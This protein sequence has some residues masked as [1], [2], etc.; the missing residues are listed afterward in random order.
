[1]TNEAEKPLKIGMVCPY[2]WAFPGG[3][4]NHTI[5]LTESLR[6]KGHDVTIIAPHSRPSD[7]IFSAGRAYPV[8]LIRGGTVARVGVSRRGYKRV[9]KF[10]RD[11]NFDIIHVQEPVAPLSLYTLSY[12]VNP[13]VNAVVTTSHTNTPHNWQTRLEALVIKEKTVRNIAANIDV[14]IAVS[15]TAKSFVERY[16]PPGQYVIIPNGVDT[17]RFS[18]DVE[19]LKG[20][21]GKT[22]LFVG[23]LGNQETRKGL[24]FLVQAFNEFSWK[25]PDTE[26]VIAG[27][28][29]PDSSTQAMLNAIDHSKIK[30]IGGVSNE[31]L[32]GLY[33]AADIFCTPATRGE[34]FG[35][36]I[37][38]AMASG[39]PVIASHIPG[40]SDVMST[41][42]EGSQDPIKYPEYSLAQVG[43]GFMVPPKDPIALARGLEIL[44]DNLSL[45]QSMGEYGRQVAESNFDWHNV[46][47]RIINEAYLPALEKRDQ[48]R[49]NAG[50]G[51][52]NTR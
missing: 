9:G 47:E 27:Y 35:I 25:R 33:R 15:E 46:C 22:V 43:Q 28:G 52:F 30:L 26:L 37:A 39:V 36:T 40:F 18:P 24:E 1:M 4:Q 49:K 32:P 16:S 5:N 17:N 11:G 38:E 20:Y 3:V 2:D 42:I 21:D 12:A 48:R 31:D 51:I 7:E 10:I 34:S 6:R 8:P 14:R 41:D 23:R 19:P 50:T 44:L 45:R 13:E 29:K